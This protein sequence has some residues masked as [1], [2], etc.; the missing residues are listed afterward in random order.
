[1]KKLALSLAVLFGVAMVSCGG[2]DN[3]E[4]ND[5]PACDSPA[6]E[7]VEEGVVAVDS[8]ND[9]VVAEGAAV[10]ATEEVP[11]EEPAK[12]EKK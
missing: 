10:E 7:T 9:S 12:E 6:V 8:T 5:S 11:A 1:M 4:C 3:K 2:K